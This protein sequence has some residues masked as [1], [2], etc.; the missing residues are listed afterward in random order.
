MKKNQILLITLLLIGVK[1]FSQESILNNKHVSP[2]GGVVKS[3]T[4]GLN[5]EMVLKD[6]QIRIFLF[7]S[8]YHILNLKHAQVSAIIQTSDLKNIKTKLTCNGVG[9]FEYTLDKFKKY[10]S[11]I[12][13]IKRAGK[14]AS[15]TFDLNEDRDG[16][17]HDAGH[18]H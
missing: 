10:I 2:N 6:H 1:S 11:A 9:Y 12:V 8:K 15:A 4:N 16:S 17:G 13:T 7:D 14:T 18:H 5:I 3:T